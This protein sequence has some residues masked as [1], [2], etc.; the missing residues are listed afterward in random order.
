MFVT[1]TPED[2]DAQTWEFLPDRVRSTEQ[3]IVEK[4]YGGTWAEFCAGVM[5]GQAHARRV[6]LCHLIRRQHPALQLRD[7]PDFMGCELVVR[8]SLAEVTAAYDEFVKSGGPEQQD[9][10]LLDSMFRAEM[11]EAEALGDDPAGKARSRN[12]PAPTSG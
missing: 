1:Y 12:E 9:G 5:K 4:H 7:T 6:L 10:A 3:V 8:Q 11:A 2:G